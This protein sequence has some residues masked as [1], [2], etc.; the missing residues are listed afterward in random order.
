MCNNLLAYPNSI[1]PSNYVHLQTAGQNISSTCTAPAVACVGQIYSEAFGRFVSFSVVYAGSG[2]ATGKVCKSHLSFFLRFSTMISSGLQQQP[3][4]MFCI[5]TAGRNRMYSN[6]TSVLQ[7]GEI[8]SIS[9]CS[10]YTLQHCLLPCTIETFSSSNNNSNSSNNSCSNESSEAT[11]AVTA[12][13]NG[14][15][16]HCNSAIDRIL[17]TGHETCR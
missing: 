1:P 13:P 17:Y 9:G 12:R 16:I 14:Q 4:C 10:L 6:A 15:Y 7:R 11:V 3:V 5:T 8:I 2:M